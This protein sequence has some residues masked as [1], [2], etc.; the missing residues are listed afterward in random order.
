MPLIDIKNIIRE[1]NM[2]H[3]N[4]YLP[5]NL[6]F[7]AGRV[8]EIGKVTAQ[9][10]KKALIVTGQSST[11]RTGLL[12]RVCGLLTDAGVE[13]LVFAEIEPNP[14]TTTVMRGA[15]TA[16]HEDCDVVIGLGGGSPMDA[17]KAIAFMACNRGDVSDYIY[18]KKTGVKALPMIAVAT[19]AGT[20]SEGNSFAVLTDPITFDKK[21]LRSN[22]IIPSAS[23]IDPELLLTM[24]KKGIASTGFDAFAHSVEAY[25]AVRGNPITGGY[26]LEA[27]RLISQHLD[28][29]LADPSN[30][31]EWS[32]ISLAATLG[33]MAIGVSGSG[34]PH[35]MEHPVS[36][37]RNV[38]H[39]EGL[40]ALFP[41]I[42]KRSWREQIPAFAQIALAMD[43]GQRMA[44]P[45]GEDQDTALAK[46][47]SYQIIKMK[48]RI[49]LTK[50]LG[51]MGITEKDLDW[52]TKN[53]MKTMEASVLNHPVP[54]NVDMIAEIYRAC[55]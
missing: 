31:E 8:S 21:A 4:Y 47:L 52:L 51:D 36:G 29:V 2:N 25:I 15:A 35:A 37:L 33:G 43:A 26:A 14:L 1:G 20:G 34:L 55:L 19:T 40:A 6:L 48:K 53:C 30:I 7:G 12:D 46:G 42:I 49:G 3:F 9:Y 24:P 10:G 13:P 32:H 41:E 16:V 39:G 22:L 23:I 50:T 44:V 5:V 18:G 45:E 28:A 11:K 54:M 27:I 38:V 17:G